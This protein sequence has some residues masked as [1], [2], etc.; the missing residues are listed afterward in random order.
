MRCAVQRGELALGDAVEDAGIAVA[1]VD[2]V[3]EEVPHFV[4]RP[5][6]LDRQRGGDEF[7]DGWRAGATD[8]DGAFAG[9]GG[10]DAAGQ[11]ESVGG[12]EVGP[13]GGEDE[14][15]VVGQARGV[16]GRPE[17][18]DRG[19]RVEPLRWLIEHAYD[20]TG[21]H[22]CDKGLVHKKSLIHKENRPAADR[23]ESA[24]DTLPVCRIGN[25]TGSAPHGAAR[26]RQ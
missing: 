20:S 5:A 24:C 2:G 9:E 25:A 23:A 11:G 13:E 10:V 14:L 16:F 21:C 12:V 18:F 15:L 26:T 22:G 17:L 4:D 7:G 1:G 3:G 6:G 8:P 19:L